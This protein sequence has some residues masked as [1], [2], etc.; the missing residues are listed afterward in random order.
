VRVVKKRKNQFRVKMTL[1]QP[2]LRLICSS[3]VDDRH[4]LQLWPKIYLGVSIILYSVSNMY[5]N[6]S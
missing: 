2:K 4:Y 1:N 3:K 5:S 6:E